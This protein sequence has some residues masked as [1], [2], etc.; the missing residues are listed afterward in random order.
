M[1][2]KAVNILMNSN[3]LMFYFNNNAIL[4]FKKSSFNT[5]QINCKHSKTNLINYN[6]SLKKDINKL[7]HKFNLYI[8]TS[9]TYK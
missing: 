5:I 8:Q 9:N 1:L 2:N 4:Q 3:H 7:K 6:T